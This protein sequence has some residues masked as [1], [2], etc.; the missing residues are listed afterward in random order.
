L[1]LLVRTAITERELLTLPPFATGRSIGALESFLT[2]P[3]THRTYDTEVKGKYMG[4]L[5]YDV[6]GQMVFRDFFKMMSE[7]P[8]GAKGKPPN[9]QRAFLMTPS[10]QQKVDQQMVDEISVFN[11]IMK[12]RN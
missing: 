7:R 3:S 2:S 6:P 9:P 11:E 10:I 12:D 4:A 8:M 1:E 5:P